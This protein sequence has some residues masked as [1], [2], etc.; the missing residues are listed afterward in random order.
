V[1]TTPG[2]VN[3]PVVL[4]DVGV[5]PGDV[6]CAD[7]DGVVVIP[8][9]EI[10]ACLE[11]C[12]RRVAAEAEKRRRLASGELAVDIDGLRTKL[13]DLGVRYIDGEPSP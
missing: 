11:R 4:G 3:V 7:D 6:V 9:D 10:E 2:S 8:F 1:K 12:E 13:R 5:N